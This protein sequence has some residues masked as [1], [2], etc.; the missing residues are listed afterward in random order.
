M[1]RKITRKELKHDEFV[2]AAFDLGHWFEQHWKPVVMGAGAVV[3]LALAVWGG[4]AL[5]ERRRQHTEALLAQGQRQF[6]QAATEGFTSDDDLSS[7][8][9]AFEG[10]VDSAGAESTTGQVALYYQA[11]TLQKLGRQQDAI[12]CLEQVTGEGN[13][14]RTLRAAASSLLASLYAESGSSSRAA[15]FLD[16]IV[17]QED[18]ALPADQALL[19]LGKIFL[20]EGRDEQARETWQRIVDDYPQTNSAAEA[21]ALLGGGAGR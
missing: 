9:A 3:V 19:Q 20:N 1:A 4:V 12:A 21:R 14:P 17:A 6:E 16:G 10:V 8:L 2:E 11:V 5:T 7:A 15:E 18:P 13:L